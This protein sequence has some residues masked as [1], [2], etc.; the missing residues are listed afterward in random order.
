MVNRIQLILIIILTISLLI[1]LVSL[2]TPAFNI[3]EARISARGHQLIQ[4]GKDELGRQ[5]PLVFNSHTDYKLPL[6]SYFSALGIGLFGKNDFGARIGFILLGTLFIYLTF[7]LSKK[8]GFN[9]QVSLFSALVV[10]LSPSLL[11]FSKIPN[12]VLLMAVFSTAMMIWVPI[13]KKKFLLPLVV[14]MIGALLINKFLWFVLPALILVSLYSSSQLKTRNGGLFLIGVLILTGAILVSFLSIPQSWRSLAENN[15]PLL[16][17]DPLTNGVNALR[18]EGLL[19]G[20]PNLIEKVLFNKAAVIPIGLLNWV[21]TFNLANFFGPIPFWPLAFLIPLALG[22]VHLI[23][24]ESL[25]L[26][27]IGLLTLALTLPILFTY[28]H[29]PSELLFLLLPIGSVIIAVG[30]SALPR[31]ILIIILAAGMLEFLI[32][33]LIILTDNRIDHYQR[34]TWI[35]QTIADIKTLQYP[36]KVFVSENLTEDTQPFLNWYGDIPTPD[37]QVDHPYRYFVTDFGQVKF[38][39]T[40]KFLPDC[41]KFG[42]IRSHFL[43]SEDYNQNRDRDKADIVKTYY[44]SKGEPRAY[45]VHVRCQINQ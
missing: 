43:S 45:W 20:W 16:A 36:N 11:F 27:N 12:E 14:L 31:K 40:R 39:D 26:K 37:Q 19:S 7:L 38:I 34:P 4:T 13:T 2:S 30:I 17:T 9:S 8:L 23:R 15:I 29:L 28:P 33:H 1:R 25:K 35:N 44:D 24:K 42:T 21:S 22:L 10:S 5:Y 6:T 18:G 32:N 41:N 3:E